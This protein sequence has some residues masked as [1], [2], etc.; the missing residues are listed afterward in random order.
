MR[1]ARE[2]PRHVITRTVRGLGRAGGSESHTT[3]IAPPVALG[4]LKEWRVFARHW[5]GLRASTPMVGA[6]PDEA[7]PSGE[8]EAREREKREVHERET[9]VR[10]AADRDDRGDR[11]EEAV[12]SGVEGQIPSRSY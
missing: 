10:D 11:T 8:S 1:A 7:S 3:A 2:A 4:H 5:V 12:R 9:E 6:M